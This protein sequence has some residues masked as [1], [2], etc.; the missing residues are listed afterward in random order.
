MQYR[1]TAITAPVALLATLLTGAPEPASALD[2]DPGDYAAA[3]P[4]TNLALAYGLFAW[5]DEFHTK[6]GDKVGNSEVDT[7][8]GILRLV[9]YTDMWGITADPQIFFPYGWVNNA[10]L[11]GDNLNSA[12]GFG[13]IILASTFWPVNQPDKKRWVGITPFLYVP[14]GNYRNKQPLN[15]GENRYKLVLQAGYVQGFQA[16]NSDW[17]LDLIVDTTWYGDNDSA[18]AN[19]TQTLSQD[20]SYQTQAWLRY[21]INQNWDIGVGYSGT[22]GGEQKIA[23]DKNGAST[24]EQQVRAITQ[25]FIRPDL[26]LQATVRTDVW[27]EGGFNE[28]FGLNIRLMK[29]F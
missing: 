25:Y 6:S 22:Y 4:G 7:Q 27:S 16:L 11:G 5:K 2:V 29:V 23:G 20:N 12:D 28:T 10:K 3:P 8:V 13:D 21:Y 17:M 24:E 18:G 14:T 1:Q 9:H 19:G 26:Q 15:L